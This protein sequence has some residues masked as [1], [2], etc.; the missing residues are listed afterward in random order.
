[1]ERKA[2]LV[3]WDGEGSLISFVVS[4]NLHRRHL[5]SNQRAF[6]ALD[7]LPFIEAEAKERQCCG[8]GGVLLSELITEANKGAAREKFRARNPQSQNLT[9]EQ[10]GS[11]KLTKVDALPTAEL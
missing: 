1:M 6:V 7:L 5:D 10:N 2:Q 4:L 9:F 11:K 8:Q 3:E